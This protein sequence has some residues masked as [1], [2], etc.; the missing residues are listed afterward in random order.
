MDADNPPP[1]GVERAEIAQGLSALQGGKTV[2][3]LWDGEICRGVGR[4]QDE[5]ASVGATFMQLARGVQIAR[6]V[7][8]RGG[9]V[10]TVAQRQRKVCNA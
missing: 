10:P 3:L 7:A 1:L 6:A 4:E 5:H 8:E 9:D 2:R